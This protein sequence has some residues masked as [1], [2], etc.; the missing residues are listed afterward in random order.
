MD[1]IELFIHSEFDNFLKK[2]NLP[3]EIHNALIN[4]RNRLYELKIKII[5]ELKV[6]KK[7]SKN[8]DLIFSNLNRINME[9]EDNPYWLKGEIITERPPGPTNKEVKSLITKTFEIMKKCFYCEKHISKTI[10]DEI[11]EEIEKTFVI[12]NNN[13]P[14]TKALY[15]RAPIIKDRLNQNL[16]CEICGENRVIDVCHIIPAEL[17]G[18]RDSYNTIHLCPTH[19]RLFDR[20]MLTED[21]WDKIDWSKKGKSSTNYV[22]HI[23]KPE[24]EKFWKNIRNNIY[25]KESGNLVYYGISS[26]EKLL[27]LYQNTILEIIKTKK[28]I[29]LKELIEESKIAKNMCLKC[30]NDMSSKKIINK[31]KVKNINYYSLRK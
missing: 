26:K 19:H 16:P 17:M 28:E 4:L 23:P 24:I 14:F 29:T 3:I 5:G 1:R 11:I 20:L 7:Y 10:T 27:E 9:R 13:L 22:Y 15:N 30:L 8:I 6:N 21:E 31:Y 2:Y 18:P 12:P 25:E